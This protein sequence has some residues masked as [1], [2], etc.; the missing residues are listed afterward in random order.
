MQQFLSGRRVRHVQVGKEARPC[1]GR[2]VDDIDLPDLGE[3][4]PWP[5]TM[6]AAGLA[7]PDPTTRLIVHMLYSRPQMVT[8]YGCDGI[9]SRMAVC[10]IITGKTKRLVDMPQHEELAAELE[11]APR[12]GQTVLVKDG[13]PMKEASARYIL[14]KFTA[15]LGPESV[16]HGLRKNAVNALLEAGCSV[17]ETASISQQSLKMVEHYAAKRNRPSWRM[18]LS[19]A[20]RTQPEPATGKL[21]QETAE[22]LAL[23]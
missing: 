20:G 19:R 17:A 13:K 15:S 3:H 7:A 23:C 6:L 9:T 1:A 22:M 4:D 16:P 5:D 14:Q 8:W 12:L 11:R 2:P 21:R 18:W 10:G